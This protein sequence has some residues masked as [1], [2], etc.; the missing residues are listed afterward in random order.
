MAYSKTRAS[1]TLMV[2]FVVLALIFIAHTGKWLLDILTLIATQDSIS[3]T[4]AQEHT[5]KHSNYK[6][7]ENHD[8]DDAIVTDDLDIRSWIVGGGG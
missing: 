1:Q 3:V 8:E 7:V 4:K 6:F 5:H 2:S